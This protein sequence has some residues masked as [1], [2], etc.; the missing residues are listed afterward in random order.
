M[1]VCLVLWFVFAFVLFFVLSWTSKVL[2]HDKLGLFRNWFVFKEFHHWSRYIKALTAVF[3]RYG[4]GSTA[5]S[6]DS[7]RHPFFWEWKPYQFLSPIFALHHFFPQ[8]KI[9]LGKSSESTASQWESSFDY[10]TWL[11]WSCEAFALAFS[12][13]WLHLLEVEI[14]TAPTQ[15]A[16]GM[17]GL[18]G[19]T[20]CQIGRTQWY[21]MIQPAFP[22]RLP[23]PSGWSVG[24]QFLKDECFKRSPFNQ[25]A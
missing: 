21:P 25:L 11:T 20:V 3:S 6:A 17:E 8:T 15:V 4:E 5:A 10:T 18:N 2:A 7:C 1:F 24:P 14:Q 13:L 23:T 9:D 19:C 16:K 22:S 12:W